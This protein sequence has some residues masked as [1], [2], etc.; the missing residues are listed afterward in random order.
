LSRYHT[1]GNLFRMSQ[2]SGQAVQPI[3]SMASRYQALL[4]VTECNSLHRDLP[5]LFSDL[6]SRLSSAVSFD[7]VSILLRDPGQNVMRFY[8]LDYFDGQT[9]ASGSGQPLPAKMDPTELPVEGSLGGFVWQTQQPLLISETDVALRFEFAV[10]FWREHGVKSLCMLPLTT[11]QR[12]L[13]AMGFGSKRQDAYSESNLEF[14][15]H[16]ARQVAIAVDNVQSHQDADCYQR[17]LAKEHDKLRLLLEVTNRVVSNLEMRELSKAIVANIRQVM[18]SDY[19]GL[20]LPEP[21]SDKLRVYALDF[22]ENKPFLKEGML[23]SVET[24]MVGKAFMTGKPFVIHVPDPEWEGFALYEASVANGW[25]SGCFLPLIS[26]GVAL[27]AL[28]LGRF[29]EQGF[30]EEDVAFLGQ[31]ANQI[32]IAVDNA[33]NYT[34]ISESRERLAEEARYLNEEIRGDLNF[35]EIIGH[36]P[37]LNRVLHQVQTVAPTDST[38]LIE[39]ETGTGKELIARAIHNRSLRRDR[40][41]VKVNCAAIP[42]G[43]LESELFGHER[44][45]FTGAIA[46]RIGRFE[47]AH[48]GTIFLDEIGDIPL[49]LQPKLLRVLQEREFERLGS[50]QTQRVDVRLIAATNQDLA[51]MVDR[52]QFRSDLYY[53]LN[54]FPIDLPPLRERKE[55]IPILIRHFVDK[56]ARSMN[57]Q[58][59]T[60]SQ[61]TTNALT[62]YAW[63]GNIRELQNIIERAVILSPGP[64]LRAPLSEL[65]RATRPLG[66][67]AGGT[68]EQT[69]R[70]HILKVLESCQW[71][72]GG[73]NGAAASLGLKR[74]TLIYKMQ[75]LGIS[76][77]QC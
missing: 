71:V 54:V 58:I 30:T 25:R 34:Q 28:F 35:E 29:Q 4:E 6:A 32:A 47:I 18:L 21:D 69:E 15:G 23:L 8:F 53:R 74:T 13:G 11:A 67:A 73:P 20:V 27:G 17:K 50:A 43:L 2:P 12:R 72:I 41:F 76:R 70:D 66:T 77:E 38:V 51:Q 42:S 26:R 3:D 22:P 5:G 48:K 59:D 57:R 49:E 19:A 55:D 7:F 10:P 63:P 65:K 36:S 60:I 24:T 52:K 31:I 44:G 14:L 45:A 46:K 1:D 9:P 61:E 68:L 62:R 64:V 37:A 16:V 75:K 56:F 33:L 39:G 40:P